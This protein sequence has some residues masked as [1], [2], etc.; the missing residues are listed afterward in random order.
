MAVSDKENSRKG[1]QTAVRTFFEFMVC[2]PM[3][4]IGMVVVSSM[5]VFGLSFIV[6]GLINILMAHAEDIS[7]EERM[8]Y[9]KSGIRSIILAIS[10]FVI[11]IIFRIIFGYDFYLF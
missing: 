2:V 11:R 5:W 3:C 6:L 7:A 10:I 1:I 4:V 9:R 8:S